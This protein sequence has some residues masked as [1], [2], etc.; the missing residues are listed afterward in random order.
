MVDL[1]LDQDQV[2]DMLRNVGKQDPDEVIVVR[3][4]RKTAASK[5][6]G[7]DEGDLYD[8]HVTKK[9]EDYVAKTNQDRVGVDRSN[10]VLTVYVTNRRGE[11]GAPGAWRRVNVAQVKKVIEADGTEHEVHTS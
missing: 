11:Q 3:C 6:G 9:P 5:P 1:Y 4:I 8:L 7:P 10:G 2:I